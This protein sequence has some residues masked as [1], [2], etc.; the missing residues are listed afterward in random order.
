MMKRGILFSSMLILS[1]VFIASSCKEDP[2][3]PS[4]GTLKVQFNLFNGADAM[5]WDETISVATVNEYRMEFFKFYLS[6]IYA[7]KTNG[8]KVMLKDVLIANGAISDGMTFLFE[9]PNGSYDKLEIGVGLDS[10]L[11]ASDPVQ[12]ANEHA[13][14]AA[15]AMYWSWAAKYRFVRID[16]RANEN[17]SIGGADDL[18]LAYHPGADEFYRKIEL[19]NPFTISGDQ[20]SNFN[21]KLDVAAFFNGPGGVI[22][23]PT[24]PQTHT[25]PS[26]YHIAV[27]FTDNFVAAFSPM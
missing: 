15:Q 21:I 12:F 16:G 6:N 10:L 19:V 4:S 23:I 24:E 18:L 13:L 20:T 7:V 17:G 14:S 5:E 3:A 27:K 22:D 8:D 9:L 25:E 1:L 11:N 26:D 2:P